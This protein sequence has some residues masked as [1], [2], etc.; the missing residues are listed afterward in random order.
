MIRL[1]LLVAVFVPTSAL[2]APNDSPRSTGSCAAESIR[3][4]LADWEQIRLD[5]ATCAFDT[6]YRFYYRRGTDPTRL[7]IYFQ[8]GGADHGL[9]RTDAFYTYRSATCVSLIGFG[10]SSTPNR[11]RVCV[12][13][14]ALRIRSAG[15]PSIRIGSHAPILA[16]SAT[17]ASRRAGFSYIPAHIMPCALSTFVSA[18]VER[19]KLFARL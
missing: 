1:L 18:S 16:C 8:G 10:V 3:P 19:S 5:D 4:R 15:Q 6:P 17:R 11:S 12:A 14:S 9:M 2:S 13:A 7:L